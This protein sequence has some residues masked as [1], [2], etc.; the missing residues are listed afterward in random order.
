MATDK[1]VNFPGEAE[2]GEPGVG[3]RTS[4]EGSGRVRR[5]SPLL[6]AADC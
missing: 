3:V 4:E 2:S 1:E 5:H 6:R